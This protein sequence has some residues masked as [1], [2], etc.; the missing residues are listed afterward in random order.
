MDNA[1]K[2][3][4]EFL[5][6]VDCEV[7]GRDA[8]LDSDTRVRLE[9]FAAGELDE[10]QRNELCELMREQPGLVAYLAEAI[11]SRRAA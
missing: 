2:T 3:I 8:V 6:R 11:K 7:E 9:Q 4:A 1:F 10:A 5:S